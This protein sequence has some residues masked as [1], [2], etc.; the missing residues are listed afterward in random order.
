MPTALITGPTAGLGA[1]FARQLAAGGYDLVLVARDAE[2]LTALAADRHGV[3][4]ETLPTDLADAT[5]RQAV[6][7][8]L[9]DE[10]PAPVDLL[11]NNA[12]FA[13]SDEF[14][15][16]DRDELQAQLDVNVTTV[17]RLT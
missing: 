7:R 15:D 1:E 9:A 8:R 17:L 6:E 2:R 3:R 11:V 5:Q 4:T 10:T 13:L 16:A 12:G 14:V